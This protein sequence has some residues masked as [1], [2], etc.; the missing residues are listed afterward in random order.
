MK[1]KRIIQI[2][3]CGVVSTIVFAAALS[4]LMKPEPIKDA[5]RE[6]E[7]WVKGVLPSEKTHK[8]SNLYPVRRLQDGRI[9]FPLQGHVPIY[10]AFFGV[11]K[12]FKYLGYRSDFSYMGGL[13]PYRVYS[14]LYYRFWL[15]LTD[16]TGKK[17]EFKLTTE[18]YKIDV[19]L[20][21]GHP[22]TFLAVGAEFGNLTILERLKI[23]LAIVMTRF[24]FFEYLLVAGV[25]FFFIELILVRRSRSRTRGNE[26][27][28]QP[29]AS[30]SEHA[31]R[32]PQ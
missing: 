12:R 7:G 20:R 21:N 15:E 17:I 18:T 26:N 6:I 13:G 10:K 5:Q 3:N 24:C 1:R 32:S 8:V 31:I 25:L 9:A 14:P 27:S 28:Q 22:W 23:T 19:A 11:P 16:K 29:D 30:D 2:L 4:L